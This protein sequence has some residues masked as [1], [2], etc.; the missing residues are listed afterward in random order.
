MGLNENA[1]LLHMYPCPP[2]SP[3]PHNTRKHLC[4]ALDRL[5]LPSILLCSPLSPFKPFCFK[6]KIHVQ[7]TRLLEEKKLLRMYYPKHFLLGP[8]LLLL[9]AAATTKVAAEFLNITTISASYGESTIECWRLAS[10]F[11]TSSTPGTSG[12]AVISLGQAG[13]VSYLSIP[14]HFDG[15]L[16]NAPAVQ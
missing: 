16:H 14:P 1:Y 11:T 2:T 8:V 5:F 7:N 3:L 13:K 6:L 9:L 12:T 10:P 4:C 15:G